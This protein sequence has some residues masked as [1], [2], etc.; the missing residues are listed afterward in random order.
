VGLLQI[1]LVH[2][3]RVSAFVGVPFR[4]REEALPYLLDPEVNVRVAYAIW[5]DQGWA[6]WSCKP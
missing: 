6:P 1:N 4:L 5:S 2:W 3:Q